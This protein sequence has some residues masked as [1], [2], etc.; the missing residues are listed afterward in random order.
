MV[1][2]PQEGHLNSVLSS[3]TVLLQDIH[4]FIYSPINILRLLIINFYKVSFIKATFGPI[5]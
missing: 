2:F 5:R 4:F 1:S 3:V